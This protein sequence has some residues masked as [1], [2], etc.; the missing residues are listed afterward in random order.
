MAQRTVITIVKKSEED[1]CCRFIV[2]KR[3]TLSFDGLDHGRRTVRHSEAV[4]EPR[5]ARLDLGRKMSDR[6]LP[7]EIESIEEGNK[8]KLLN[9]FG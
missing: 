5:V 8:R 2:V 6:Q 7:Y 4:S 3:M 9:A 1:N